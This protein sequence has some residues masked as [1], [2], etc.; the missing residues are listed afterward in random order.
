MQGKHFKTQTFR[1]PTVR[2]YNKILKH[3]QLTA[4]W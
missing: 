1:I 2:H 4:V 3:I